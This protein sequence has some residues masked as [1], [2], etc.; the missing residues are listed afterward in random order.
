MS[1]YVIGDCVEIPHRLVIE[2]AGT[3][4][5]GIIARECWAYRLYAGEDLI[6]SGNDLGTPPAVSEDRAA[7]HALVFLTLRPGDT[8]PEWFSGYTPEQVAWCDTHAESL[9]ECLWDA[10]GDEIEDLSVYRVA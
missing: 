9:G 1:E 4:T 10:S 3:A 5:E 6:F 2:P 8:D 7:T